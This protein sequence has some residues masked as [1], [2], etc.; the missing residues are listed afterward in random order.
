MSD[1]FVEDLEVIVVSVGKPLTEALLLEYAAGQPRDKKGRFGSTGGGGG[2]GGGGVV[3]AQQVI[4]VT[5]ENEGAT[6]PTGV[7]SAGVRVTGEQPKSGYAVATGI[8]GR[9][10][11]ADDF[12]DRTKGVEIVDKFL[13]DNAQ[14]FA[15]PAH[16]LG[17][18]HETKTGRVHLDITEVFP[19]GQRRV[20]VQAGRDRDQISIFNLKTLKEI[21][22]GGKGGVQESEDRPGA[23]GHRYDDAR[24]ATESGGA[25]V[26][27]AL[28]TNPGEPQAQPA[29]GGAGRVAGRQDFQGL[30]PN[31]LIAEYAKR[32]PTWDGC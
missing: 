26:G 30:T 2:G 1:K 9:V 3:D 18:W 14:H 23:N 7:G 4:A 13:A 29:D 19:A 10:V 17:T 28:R 11:S 27:D 31:E 16:H 6:L 12:F 25:V 8:A 21:P 24:R 5:R 22:T 20:A 15:N 32:N